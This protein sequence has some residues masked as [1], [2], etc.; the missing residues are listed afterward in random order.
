MTVPNNIPN[1]MF[2]I[3]YLAFGMRKEATLKFESILDLNIKCLASS[4]FVLLFRVQIFHINISQDYYEIVDSLT[5]T[6]MHS[7]A[8][9]SYLF[10][11]CCLLLSSPA[12]S[13][14]Q[15]KLS[16]SGKEKLQFTV[17]NDRDNKENEQENVDEV[18][19]GERI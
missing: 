13:P 7:V 19:L 9:C 17:H 3:Q 18:R 14:A 16:K 1:L 10:L 8:N 12:F 2:T 15:A 4:T 6:A 11:V 5:D